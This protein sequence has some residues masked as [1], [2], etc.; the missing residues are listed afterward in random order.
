[1]YD[2]EMNCAVGL[3]DKAAVPK[4]SLTTQRIMAHW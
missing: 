3:P 4:L 1:M 2:H